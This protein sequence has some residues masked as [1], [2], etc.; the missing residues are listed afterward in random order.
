MN[1]GDDVTI[2]GKIIDI[3]KDYIQI[4]TK[5]GFSFICKKEDINTYTPATVIGE[6]RR[7]GS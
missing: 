1:V 3:N 6:D 4:E 2:N 5:N 7:K